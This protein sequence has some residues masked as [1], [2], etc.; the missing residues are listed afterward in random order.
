MAVFAVLVGPVDHDG[1][2]YEE[3]AQ[4]ELSAAE[5]APLVS[6]GIIGEA[7]KRKRVEAES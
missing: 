7:T 6:L 5:S 1:A 3:G 2:R 4:L